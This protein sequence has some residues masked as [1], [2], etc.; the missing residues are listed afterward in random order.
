MRLPFLHQACSLFLLRVLCSR[1]IRSPKPEYQTFSPW[2]QSSKRC[3]LSKIN[4]RS[5]SL[6][7]L[8][9]HIV[10]RIKCNLN[11]FGNPSASQKVKFSFPD[12][13]LFCSDLKTCY[14]MWFIKI[15]IRCI[16]SKIHHCCWLEIVLARTQAEFFVFVLLGLQ[17][18]VSR[19]STDDM[20]PRNRMLMII[21]RVFWSSV[22]HRKCA[23]VVLF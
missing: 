22:C 13:L 10:Q 19:N 23:C 5:F 12:P 21:I 15:S 4:Q 9:L 8:S 17:I 1:L 2:R 18:F 20:R 11:T 6:H 14:E 7:A 16:T 3:S